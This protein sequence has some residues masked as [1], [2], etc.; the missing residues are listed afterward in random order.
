VQTAP[1]GL[2][3]GWKNFYKEDHP[4]LTPAQTM[5]QTPTPLM[6]SYQ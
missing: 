1:K 4:V 5:A 3:F 2:P 6:I